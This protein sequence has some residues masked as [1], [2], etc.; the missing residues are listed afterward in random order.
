[1]RACVRASVRLSVPPPAPSSL[2]PLSSSLFPL[3][4]SLFPPLCLPPPLSLS[5]S[6]A[7][8]LF[9]SVQT[10]MFCLTRGG[11]QDELAVSES[12]AELLEVGVCVCVCLCLCL[13]VGGWVVCECVCVLVCVCVFRCRR[14]CACVHAWLQVEC[15]CACSSCV[16]VLWR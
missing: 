12:I 8:S 6:L 9:A 10:N 7:P 13:C 1:M 3:P 15:V 16:E 14:V 2:F 11:S 4:S 5:L